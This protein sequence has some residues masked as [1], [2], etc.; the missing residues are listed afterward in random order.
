VGLRWSALVCMRF[1]MIPAE[2]R[3][4]LTGGNCHFRP[5]PPMPAR[6]VIRGVA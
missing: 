4:P 3:I 5:S 6:T 1:C 2:L